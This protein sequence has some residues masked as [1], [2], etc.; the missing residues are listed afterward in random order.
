MKLTSTKLYELRE[1]YQDCRD[2]YIFYANRCN[3]HTSCKEDAQ[4]LSFY[5][6]QLHAMERVFR[7]LDMDFDD[8]ASIVSPK[9]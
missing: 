5:D 2:G 1:M 8:F 9:E 6:G 4:W 7:A 3:N